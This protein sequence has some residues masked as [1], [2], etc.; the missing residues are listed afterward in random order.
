MRDPLRIT[1]LHSRL[2]GHPCKKAKSSHSQAPGS[3]TSCFL[4]M[5]ANLL[6]GTEATDFCFRDLKARVFC[7]WILY[8]KQVISA[9]HLQMYRLQFL[10]RKNKELSDSMDKAF[11][12]V[13]LPWIYKKAVGFLNYLQVDIES[14]PAR[15]SLRMSC[16][17]KFSN[18]Y[19]FS[20][21]WSFSLHFVLTTKRLPIFLFLWSAYYGFAYSKPQNLKCSC[22]LQIFLAITQYMLQIEDKDTYFK[23]TLKAG[24]IMDV[25]EQYPWSG[26]TVE[27]SRRY[28]RPGSHHGCVVKSDDGPQLQW[29]VLPIFLTLK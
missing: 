11:A 19:T 12:S 5:L 3:K 1:L 9:S 4:R 22:A 2:P 8:H 14:T 23:T 26:E 25:V 13:K 29:V 10:H 24:G 15:L 28:K 27:H 20:S 21:N 18:F 7:S 17:H 6:R 16:R